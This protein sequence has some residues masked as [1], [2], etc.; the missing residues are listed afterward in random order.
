VRRVN[1]RD[2]LGGGLVLL[3][4]VGAA[5]QASQ[6]E[7][8][9]LRRMGPGYF[10][11]ALGVILAVTG[12]LIMLASLR[13]AIV[14]VLA[15]Q[16]PEWRGWFCICASMVLFA[17]IGTYG[18]LLPATFACVFI[19]ALGD[20]KNTLVA[21]AVLAAAMTLVCLIV[22]WWLLKVNLPLFDWN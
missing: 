9:S 16:R 15:R 3:L 5:L 22:F 7:L 18:G 13:T 20:R 21:S 1:I 12:A 14:P 6:Y 19:A 10:P 2:F 11:L 8:G 17:V 4:G